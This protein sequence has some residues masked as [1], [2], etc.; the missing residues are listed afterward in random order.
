MTNLQNDMTARRSGTRGKILP[1]AREIASSENDSVA[2]ELARNI[3]RKIL[4][5]TTALRF[6]VTIL[7]GVLEQ[8]VVDSLLS[9]RR[10]RDPPMCQLPEVNFTPSRAKSGSY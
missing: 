7:H 1:A 10:I 2:L 6:L 8:S 3:S 9:A 5:R 4:T